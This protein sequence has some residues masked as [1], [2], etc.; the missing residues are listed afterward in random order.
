[1][2]VIK[3]VAQ[4]VLALPEFKSVNAANS[5]IVRPTV[6]A[7]ESAVLSLICPIYGRER[8]VDSCTVVNSTIAYA[9]LCYPSP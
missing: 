9:T 3:N 6:Q 7:N 2:T 4:M 5:T 1:M 8:L